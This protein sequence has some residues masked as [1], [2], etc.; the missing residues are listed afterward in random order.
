L[1]WLEGEAALAALPDDPLLLVTHDDS[2]H[3]FNSLS[4][5]ANGKQVRGAAMSSV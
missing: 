3:A 4:R 5:V 1:P 2:L